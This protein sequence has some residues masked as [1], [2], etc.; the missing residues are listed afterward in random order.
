MSKSHRLLALGLFATTSLGFL[1]ARAQGP[2]GGAG[3][4]KTFGTGR[5]CDPAV[6][7]HLPKDAI[8]NACGE[9]D[10]TFLGEQGSKDTCKYFFKVEGE[11]DNEMYVQVYSPAEKGTPAVPA[12]PFVTWKKMPGGAMMAEPKSLRGNVNPKVK[13]MAGDT[14]GAVGLWKA[15]N[16]YSVMVSAPA[17]VCSRTDAKRLAGSI[18]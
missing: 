12:D 9:S 17:K 8:F 4:C 7:M 6:S 14:S 15:G 2:G 11:K 10:A 1:T 16:G 3:S 13:A 18:K 5:C